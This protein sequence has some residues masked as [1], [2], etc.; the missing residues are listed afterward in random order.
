MLGKIPLNSAGLPENMSQPKAYPI[1]YGVLGLLAY[2]GPMSGYD[3]KQL[4]DQAMS[5]MWNATQRQIYNELNRIEEFGWA[6]MER[7][8][9]E[10]RPDKKVYQITAEGHEA[11]RAWQATR[12]IKPLQ[13]R[14][15]ML[16]R[17]TF[18][19]F[20][21]PDDLANTLGASIFEHE[22]RMAQYLD[23]RAML[24]TGPAPLGKHPNMSAEEP[25]DPFFLEMTRFAFKFEEMYLEWLRD[26]LDFVE[27]HQQ[28]SVDGADGINTD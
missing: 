11:L 6:T 17:F 5:P 4:F 18:G 22:K 28:N 10:N 15:E 19:A 26:A 1:T 24:P 25:R 8:R 14:D 2:T 13:I 3:L 7:K 20:A 21:T 27:S 9:Q 23:S 16:M 12:P